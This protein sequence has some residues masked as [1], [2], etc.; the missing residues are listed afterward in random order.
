MLLAEVFGGDLNEAFSRNPKKKKSFANI[1][2]H[3]AM[4]VDATTLSRWVKAANLVK[5]FEQAGKKFKYLTCSHYIALL[6]LKDN[7]N[8]VRLA[9]EAEKNKFSVRKLDLEVYRAEPRPPKKLVAE[10]SSKLGSVKAVLDDDSVKKK[11]T[12]KTQLATKL[13]ATELA[14][15]LTD[16]EVAKMRAKKYVDALSGFQ[17]LLRS[18]KKEGKPKDK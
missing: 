6:S 10:I 3:P 12:N 14:R 15:L 1:C 17:D 4:D 7:N 16:V 18:I 9:E 2:D 8:R 5:T 11:L 13:T